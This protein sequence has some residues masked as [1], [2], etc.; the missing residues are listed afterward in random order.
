L[1]AVKQAIK[2]F[3]DVTISKIFFGETIGPV[4]E[5]TKVVVTCKKKN[6][7]TIIAANLFF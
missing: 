1:F 7:S 3:A 5:Q 6:Y 2:E 4:C